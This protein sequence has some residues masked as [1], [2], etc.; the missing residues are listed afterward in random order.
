MDRTR[1]YG[2][3]YKQNL[4]V[5]AAAYLVAILIMD[6]T[7]NDCWAI[8]ILK[9]TVNVRW[10][11]VKGVDVKISN[12]KHNLNKL[13]TVKSN[14]PTNEKTPFKLT[15]TFRL[16]ERLATKLSYPHRLHWIRL[17]KIESLRS[18][19][20]IQLFRFVFIV[21]SF[22]VPKMAQQAPKAAQ[23]LAQRFVGSLKSKE[24]REYLTR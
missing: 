9:W 19:G 22:A 14:T 7:D 17:I 24:F 21:W 5:T 12:C 2:F 1:F 13:G 4:S 16:C 23:S 3:N 10:Y 20:S 15:M 6:R 8:Y 18:F 11:W